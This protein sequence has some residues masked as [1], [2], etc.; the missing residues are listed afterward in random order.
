MAFS[1]NGVASV[2][3]NNLNHRGLTNMIDD[4]EMEKTMITASTSQLVR[5]SHLVLSFSN[6]A[7][8]LVKS[9]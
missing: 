1:Q 2:T 3:P 8:K 9:W 4:P 5:S 6:M 7:T